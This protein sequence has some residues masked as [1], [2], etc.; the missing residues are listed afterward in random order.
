[1][2]EISSSNA[3]MILDTMIGYGLKANPKGWIASM[4][5]KIN[6]LKTTVLALD[7]PSGLDAST[8][9]IH[10]P[11]I[12]A[13]ATM[14]LAL[15][16]SGLIKENAKETVGNLYLC[17]ICIPN[18]LYKEIGLQVDPIFVKDNIIKLDNFQEI[19]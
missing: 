5:T 12:R 9:E 11:C 10:N 4:I 2:Q 15:P 13:S 7:V 1:Y 19:I 14:T 3:E 17:D 6:E 8:G 18:V 16:K